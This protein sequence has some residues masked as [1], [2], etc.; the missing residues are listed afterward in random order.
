MTAGPHP[1][2]NSFQVD[3]HGAGDGVEPDGGG[4]RRHRVGADVPVDMR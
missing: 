1:S 3:V 4:V 2:V